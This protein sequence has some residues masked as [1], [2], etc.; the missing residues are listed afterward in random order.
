MFASANFI[1]IALIAAIRFGYLGKAFG[2]LKCTA[3]NIVII[4]R[5][6]VIT[7]PKL[8]L[9]ER[10]P[11]PTTPAPTLGE[12]EGERD[13]LVERLEKGEAI[14]EEKRVQGFDVS[15]LIDKWINLLHQYEAIC[16]RIRELKATV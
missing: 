10:G 9:L 2:M 14:I 8:T 11:E 7:M 3:T 16:D 6:K 15:A 13:K 1:L 4:T 5:V 12:L